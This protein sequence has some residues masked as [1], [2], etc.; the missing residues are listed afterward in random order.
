MYEPDNF[1]QKDI[2]DGR[3]GVKHYIAV[4]LGFEN[5]PTLSVA[6]PQ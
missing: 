5:I 1:I 4:A 3:V 6:L 2:W